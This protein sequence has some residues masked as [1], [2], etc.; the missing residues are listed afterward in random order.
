MKLTQRVCVLVMAAVVVLAMKGAQNVEAQNIMASK[1][2]W[3]GANQR[4]CVTC[5]FSM[6]LQYK[7]ILI[8]TF[9]RL[10]SGRN[11]TNL[12]SINVQYPCAV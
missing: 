8:A 9:C 12:V 3:A 5:G 7:V 6:V 4:R 11:L 2:I 1:L 10:F